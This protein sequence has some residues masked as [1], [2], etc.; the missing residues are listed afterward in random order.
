MER[1]YGYLLKMMRAG[2]LTGHFYFLL[3]SEDVFLNAGDT[4]RLIQNEYGS[5]SHFTLTGAGFGQENTS[6]KC[7]SNKPHLGTD[8]RCCRQYA[9]DEANRLCVGLQKMFNLVFI[10]DSNNAKHLSIEPFNDYMASRSF[11]GLDE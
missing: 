10:P 7:F 8:G 5:E 4:V 2:S 9:R 1:L 6:L 3:S 11:K